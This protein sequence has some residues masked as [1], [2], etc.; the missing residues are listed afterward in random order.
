MGV[1]KHYSQE[2]GYLLEINL[3]FNVFSVHSACEHRMDRKMISLLAVSLF[4]SVR[5]E[6]RARHAND[7]RA[8][9][10]SNLKKKK[11]VC[12]LEHDRQ[13]SGI[14]LMDNPLIRN[15]FLCPDTTDIFM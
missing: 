7:A 9:P 3:V 4:F 11:S 14:C 10:S 5:Q 6:K 12:S 15:S 13:Y 1:C 8:L 2:Q